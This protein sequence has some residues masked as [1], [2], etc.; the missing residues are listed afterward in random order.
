MKI[1]DLGRLTNPLFCKMFFN[2]K[3]CS[4]NIVKKMKSDVCFK[5]I[6]I[7]SLWCKLQLTNVTHIAYSYVWQMDIWIIFSFHSLF[8]AYILKYAVQS[9][10]QGL[11]HFTV[12][13]LIY[14]VY[15]LKTLHCYIFNLM[16]QYWMCTVLITWPRLHKHYK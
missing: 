11:S 14:T 3:H 1:L 9:H 15:E 8:S 16:T 10:G 12:N 5:R 6:N 4:F 7:K 2:S 13:V